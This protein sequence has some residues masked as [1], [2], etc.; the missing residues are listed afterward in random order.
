MVNDIFRDQIRRNI[1]VYVHDIT[2]K[3]KKV[4]M[5][6]QDMREILSK[7]RPVGDDVKPE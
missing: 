1:E 6:P 5:L 3:S 4:D 2:L 7:I